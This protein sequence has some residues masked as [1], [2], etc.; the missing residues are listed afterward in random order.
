[1]KRQRSTDA[2]NDADSVACEIARRDGEVRPMRVLMVTG[3]YYPELSGGGLQCRELVRSLRS[4]VAF[5]I[6]STSIDPRLPAQELVEGIWVDRIYV[7][8]QRLGSQ[9]LALL[10][11]VGVFLRCG[12]HCEIIHMHGFSRKAIP[13]TILAMLSRKKIM[14]TLQTGGHDEP[15]A[16]RSKG[17]V[18]FWC[19]RQADLITGVSPRLQQAYRAAGLPSN[20]FRLIPNSV[21]TGH[22]RPG[23]EAE[24]RHL[25]QTLR[26]PETLPLMLFVGFFSR[27]KRPE[28]LFDAWV[29]LEREGRLASGIVFV[30]ATRS[31]YY[32]VDPALA[33]RIRSEIR[34]LR[35]E[36]RVTFVEV[37]HTIEWYYR[38]V[39]LFVLP[40]IREGMPIALLE[41]M[42]SGLPCVATRLAGVTD[43][44]IH[45]GA[46]GL[47]VPPGDV[48]AL[49]AALQTLLQD[50]NR[51]WAMGRKARKSM[52]ERYAIGHA[53]E[54]FL[55][56]YEQL[57]N[58][59]I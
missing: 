56:S 14:L 4:R 28:V 19:Y 39:D 23:D 30:G 3:A 42:A 47:L 6:L 45:D 46:N 29:R 10:R 25:R 37:T 48:E 43:A 50:P 57:L 9:L 17:R 8:I 51:A 36:D 33:Q 24:R 59:A 12:H 20:K 1:M 2:V 31:S 52:E 7:D 41:A 54:Q 32:E 21:D 40:S 44:V 13:M 55:Q 34:R 38:A 11:L 18:A 27:E 35:V 16:I 15:P 22:F 5:R 53:A 58:D 26:L 49:K